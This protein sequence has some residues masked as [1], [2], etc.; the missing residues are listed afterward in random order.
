MQDQLARRI[1]HRAY[2]HFVARGGAHGHALED[3]LV[4]EAEITRTPYEVVLVA[5]GGNTIELVRA[6]RELTS[7]GLPEIRAAIDAPPQVIQRLPSLIEAEAFR[8]A[9]APT[10]ATVELRAAAS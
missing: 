5:A 8:A 6:I 2:E 7:R 1:A 9:L 3:W 10:G 4:A